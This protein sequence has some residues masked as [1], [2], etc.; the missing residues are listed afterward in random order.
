MDTRV[1]AALLAVASVVA[2]TPAVGCIKPP[3]PFDCTRMVPS[4]DVKTAAMPRLAILVD[5]SNS[6]RSAESQGSPNY[7]TP[8]AEIVSTAAEQHQLVSV[9]AFSGGENVDWVAPGLLTPDNDN[10]DN[11]RQL[12]IEGNKCLSTALGDALA[13]DPVEPGTDILAAIRRAAEWVGKGSGAKRIVVATDGLPTRGCAN[14]AGARLADDT[15]LQNIAEVC[16]GRDEVNPARLKGMDLTMI[17]V[18]WSAVEY[19][20]IN[21]QQL[22]QLRRLWQRLCRANGAGD[23]ECHIGTESVMGN[24][25]AAKPR[26]PVTGVQDPPVTFGGRTA[27]RIPSAALFDTG[28]SQVRQEALALLTRIAVDIRTADKPIQ[29]VVEGHADSRGGAGDNLVLSKQRAEAVMR[30]LSDNGVKNL[31]A[32]GFGDTKPLCTNQLDE[33]CLQQNRRVEIIV[34]PADNG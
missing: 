2:M 19:P 29:V 27:Y 17:G 3:P 28:V 14:V 26:P 12:I 10:D 5:V 9:A 24:D 15:E 33:A 16:Q 30:V 4:P 13:R 6:T 21:P 34:I 20:S 32:V 18:G 22:N 1:K 31:R 25:E 23:Q 8:L 7:L 11:R